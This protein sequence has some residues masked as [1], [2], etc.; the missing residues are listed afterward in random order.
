MTRLTQQGTDR[1]G[2]L[3][4]LG[5]GGAATLGGGVLLSACGSD[6]G[7]TSDGL[8]KMTFQANFLVNV[9]QLGEVTALEK[10]FYRDEGLDVS[11]VQG[12]PSVDPTASVVGGHTDLGEFN[13]SPSLFL[14]VSE[15]RPIK[16]FAAAAQRHPYAYFSLPDN[17]VR[18]PKDM[19]GKK[20]GVNQTGVILL[21]AL[22]MENGLNKDDVE[23]VTISG[24]ATPLL[25]GQVDV[26]TGWVTQ[27]GQLKE[28]PEDYVTMT[29]WDAGIPLYALG[30]FAT[31]EAL[32]KDSE[33]LEAFTRASAKGWFYARE[34][35]EEAVKALT[36]KYAELDAA[37]ELIAADK[38]FEHVFPEGS[39]EWGTM[40]EALWEK[41]MDIYDGLGLF[42]GDRPDVNQVMTQQILEATSEARQ[43]GA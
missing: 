8:K 38:I 12:G 42:K 28:L 1:R 29:L 43:G 7:T 17:P 27:Q 3:Q 6:G 13:S 20:I 30:Y 2:F 15:G 26:W 18:T 21:E 39:N 10:D 5:V 41:Q 9:S 14:G 36:S 11:I 34:N 4:I 33:T 31:N 24:E 22:L 37:D 32:E 35:P 19:V 25:T 23:I 40:D 16:S